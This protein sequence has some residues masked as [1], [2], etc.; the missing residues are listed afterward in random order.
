MESYINSLTQSWERK[1]LQR[2][3][4][5]SIERAEW[6]SLSAEKQNEIKTERLLRIVATVAG[7]G[8]AATLAI[9]LINVSNDKP[10]PVETACTNL[11]QQAQ[12]VAAAAPALKR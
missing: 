8:Y 11:P 6:N 3:L 1:K 7:M 4:E 10:E 2:N 5:K 9:G 12:A